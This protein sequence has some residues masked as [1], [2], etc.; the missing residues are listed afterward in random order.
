MGLALTAFGFGLAGAVALISGLA[1]FCWLDAD[2]TVFGAG[3]EITGALI[4]VGGGAVAGI[5]A[6]A[7]A[8]CGLAPLW[9]VDAR[10]CWASGGGK[11]SDNLAGSVA[12][13]SCKADPDW[14]GSVGP[15]AE[16]SAFGTASAIG[17]SD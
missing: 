12:C 6:K 15:A 8:L 16:F 3:G 17:G 9:L 7:G 1:I 5:G 14:F 10:G 2:G 4:S 13:G 11:G